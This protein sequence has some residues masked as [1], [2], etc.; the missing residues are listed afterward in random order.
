M[1][2]KP[3]AFGPPWSSTVATVVTAK[4]NGVN[5]AH[6]GSAG[7]LPLRLANRHHVLYPVPC[8]GEDYGHDRLTK[9]ADR[10]ACPHPPAVSHREQ[11]VLL[12]KQKK[13]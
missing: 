12:Y 5:K 13:G 11:H 3:I 4:C 8:I 10:R 9:R 6:T 7:G 1:S 2:D